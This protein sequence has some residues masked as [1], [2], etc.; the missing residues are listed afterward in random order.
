MKPW[1]YIYICLRTLY[2]MKV[3]SYRQQVYLKYEHYFHHLQ[4]LAPAESG[5]RLEHLS[6]ICRQHLNKHQKPISEGCFRER[7]GSFKN[8]SVR[9]G[10][11]QLLCKHHNNNFN[12]KKYITSNCKLQPANFKVQTKNTPQRTTPHHDTHRRL[13]E[14][15][16]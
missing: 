5:Y 8:K 7:Q 9:L 11:P 10:Y 14:C 12:F 13:V 1:R 15:S 3:G 2:I 4:P 6:S 16:S